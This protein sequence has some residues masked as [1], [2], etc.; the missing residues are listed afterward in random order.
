MVLTVITYKI[1]F[2]LIIAYEKHQC[3]TN[4]LALQKLIVMRNVY[5][6]SYHCAIL[7]EKTLSISLHVINCNKI[8]RHFPP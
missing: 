2:S 4:F 8:L 1:F 5:I 7:S 3:T 6:I